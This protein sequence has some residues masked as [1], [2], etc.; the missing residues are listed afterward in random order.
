[1]SLTT[2]CPR[3]KKSPRVK[4]S[5]REAVRCSKRREKF[6]VT[7]IGVDDTQA[8]QE[9]PQTVAG[10]SGARSCEKALGKAW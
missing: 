7:G 3:C 4:E 1:M 8:S 5:Q 10:A 6:T 2:V 9:A